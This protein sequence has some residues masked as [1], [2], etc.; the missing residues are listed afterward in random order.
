LHKGLISGARK[1]EILVGDLLSETLVLAIQVLILLLISV[2]ALRFPLEGSF[3]LAF[4][5]L[6]LQGI[7]GVC[8]GMMLAFTCSSGPSLILSCVATF[9]PT[10]MLCGNRSYKLTCRIVVGDE[11]LAAQVKVVDATT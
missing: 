3:F 9:Y 10:I 2:Y 4:F 8:F 11:V 7:C 1:W 6:L 5:L